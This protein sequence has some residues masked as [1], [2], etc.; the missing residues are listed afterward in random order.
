AAASDLPVVLQGETGTGKEVVARSL[1]GFSGRPGELVAVNCA[2]LPEGLAEAELFG[3]RRGAFTGA[4]RASA[5]F[6]RAAHGG[7][8]LLDEVS[9]LPMPV[10]AK[11]LRVLEQ[12]VV[13]PIGAVRAVY[14]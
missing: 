12:R 4:D 9:D 13:L 7:T 11:M 2:A 3:Y 1:H 6:F 14:I 8:L 5:G 10:Q